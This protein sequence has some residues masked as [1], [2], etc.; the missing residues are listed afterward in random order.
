MS[1]FMLCKTSNNLAKYG[2]TKIMDCEENRAFLTNVRDEQNRT[3][4]S[5]SARF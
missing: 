4:N 3:G 2:C 1:Q 5:V